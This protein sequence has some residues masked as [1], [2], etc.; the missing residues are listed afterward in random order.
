MSLQ[1]AEEGVYII[2]PVEFK[3]DDKREISPIMIIFLQFIYLNNYLAEENQKLTYEECQNILNSFQ[4]N[5]NAMFEEKNKQIM[6]ETNQENI[7]FYKLY[8]KSNEL[9]RQKI[10]IL[11]GQNLNELFFQNQE[12]LLVEDLCFIHMKLCIRHRNIL[13]SSK[14]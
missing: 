3:T 4:W 12:Y 9:V 14:R 13:I 7:P 8:N 2:Y 11:I 1:E 5:L 10:D 6:G